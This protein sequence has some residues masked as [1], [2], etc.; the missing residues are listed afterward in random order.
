MDSEKINYAKNIVNEKMAE[1]VKQFSTE[2]D[3]AKSQELE[4]RIDLLQ[5]IKDQIVMGNDQVIKKV[6]MKKEEGVF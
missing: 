4:K 1:L 3:D 2:K 6:I 5:E